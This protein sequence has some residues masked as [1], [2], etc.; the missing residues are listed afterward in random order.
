MLTISLAQ[1]DRHKCHSAGSRDD[2]SC[3]GDKTKGSPNRHKSHSTGSRDDH[4]CPG[5]KTIVKLDRHKSH[6]AS[7]R[8]DN[9][10]PVGK[11]N[12]DQSNIEVGAHAE[13]PA[14][15]N[16]GHPGKANTS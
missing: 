6:S 12:F 3:P 5:G 4:L 1:S 11:I 16:I 9:L 15:K 7:G 8:D 10:C 14:Q 2:H 13:C